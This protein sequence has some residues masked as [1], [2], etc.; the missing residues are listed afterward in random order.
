MIV[1]IELKVKAATSTA[2]AIDNDLKKQ[3]AIITLV[4]E[5]DHGELCDLHVKLAKITITDKPKEIGLNLN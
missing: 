3:T 2:I 5:G 4:A 1:Y